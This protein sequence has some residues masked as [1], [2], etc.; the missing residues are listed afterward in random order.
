M[1]TRENTKGLSKNRQLIINI[2]ASFVA[3]FVSMG[4][5]FFLSP[6]IV[7]TVGVEAYGFVQL[8]NNIISYLAILAIA[9]NSMSSRFIS[10]E[11]FRGNKTAANEYFTST[12]YSNILLGLV[13][14]PIIMVVILNI[15]RLVNIPMEIVLDVQFLLAFLSLNFI[16]GLLAT[17]LGV[18]YYITNKLYINSLIQIAGHLI[19]AVLLILLFGLFRPYVSYVALSALIITILTQLANLYYKHRLIPELR[20]NRKYFNFAKVRE[21]VGSGLWNSITRL[22]S[23]LS[24]GLDLLIA[25]L[26]ISVT[27]MGILSI[28]KIIP[29]LI[30]MIL[31]SMI[32]SFLPNMTEL[33]AHQKHEELVATIKQSMRIIGMI[34]NIPIALLI[35]FGDVLFT[36]W[37]PTQDAQLLQLLSVLTV[38]PW[39]FMG[40]ATIIHNIFTIVNRI[41]LNSI[42]ITL[43]GLL[44][45]I[46]VFIL[47]KT[48]QMGLFAV[49]GVSAVLS[50][51]RNG[52]YTVPFGAKYIHKPWYTFYP[53]LIKSV[54]SVTLISSLGLMLKSQMSAYS[55]PNL[56]MMSFVL[57]VMGMGLNFM[58]IFRK[59]DRK[60]IISLIKS[61]LLR[62]GD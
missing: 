47:L 15:S 61:K 4:I 9:L 43:T 31:N 49:A 29:N 58:I 48:T 21:L 16:I 24:E 28:A 22:G 27:G 41:K 51:L 38:L 32:S 37:F 36:V 23:L 50:V 6:Y 54:L 11:Y 55:W 18:S 19:K 46:I 34:I 10:I 45:V 33:Y 53:D 44:N 56:I 20:V 5:N 8:G 59:N 1:Q 13:F 25:N 35:A 26:M 42:L 17:N 60:N 62:K 57:S 30:N 12:F 2:M 14:T 7:A 52:L 3:L 40:Q 39:A